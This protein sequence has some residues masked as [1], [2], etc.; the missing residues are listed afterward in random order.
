MSPPLLLIVLALAAFLS[1]SIPFGYVIGRT[2]GVD[3]RQHGS[4]NIGATNV[5]RVLGRP[6]GFLCFGLDLL[7]GLLPTLGAGAALGVLG[8]AAPP[9]GLAWAWLGVMAAS[10]LG[11]MFS[12]WV[13]FK[14]GKGVATGFGA[15]L[16]VWPLLTLPA[17][18]ALGVWL[19]TLAATRYVGLS[20]CLAATSLPASVLAAPVALAA[21]G[22]AEAQP[23]GAG[24]PWPHLIVATVLGGL[25]V[26][27]HRG[28]LARVWAGTEPKVGRGARAGR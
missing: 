12:P 25:V 22:L 15:L 20:S 21:V 26:Y 17:V 2:R 14:G 1:G 7:K 16:G 8:S 6:W 10:V 5:G 13:G 19:A 27:K 28:N 11:H 23:G 18:V 4:R 24:T 3:I 9:A